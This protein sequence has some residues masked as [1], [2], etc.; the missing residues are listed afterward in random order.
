MDTE[1]DENQNLKSDIDKR[2][3]DTQGVTGTEESLNQNKYDESENDELK[4]TDYQNNSN[5]G[6]TEKIL[7]NE[8]NQTHKKKEGAIEN[9]LDIDDDLVVR[10]GD[11]INNETTEDDIS[12]QKENYKE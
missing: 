12:N 11:V 7:E 2:Q 10:N 5:T 6:Y 9:K 1:R 4:D 3:K 8:F